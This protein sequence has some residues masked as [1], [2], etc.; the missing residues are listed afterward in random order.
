[1]PAGGETCEAALL[2]L[3]QVLSEALRRVLPD[4]PGPL[5][6]S[7]AGQG[8]DAFKQVSDSGAALAVRL[9]STGGSS[10]ADTAAFAAKHCSGCRQDA[11]H[12]G[13]LLVRSATDVL[14]IR[15]DGTAVNVIIRGATSITE[16][17]LIEIAM[18][19]GLTLS[20]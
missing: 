14:S 13:L 8:Y 16:Q 1:V 3:N 6:L 15:P 9:R 17:Q 11:R 2:R 5:L 18:T 12:G 4:L 19:P 20:R 10:D 7:P